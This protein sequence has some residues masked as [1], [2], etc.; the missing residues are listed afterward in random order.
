MNDFSSGIP[1]STADSGPT[2][3]TAQDEA[4]QGAQSRRVRP[5]QAP[6]V[7]LDPLQFDSSIA[8]VRSLALKVQQ[9]SRSV[10]RVV[11]QLSSATQVDSQG[12]LGSWLPPHPLLPAVDRQN[13]VDLAPL[14]SWLRTS[15][16]EHNV[17]TGQSESPSAQELAHLRKTTLA[18][19]QDLVRSIEPLFKEIEVFLCGLPAWTDIMVE[20][21]AIGIDVTAE[22]TAWLESCG[23]KVTDSRV[24]PTQWALLL[25]STAQRLEQRW[26]SA[27][28]M[29]QQAFI[30]HLRSEFIGSLSGALQQKLGQVRKVIEAD[31]D[32]TLPAELQWIDRARKDVLRAHWACA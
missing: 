13:L 29:Y 28:V 6:C 24:T 17:E 5:E 3:S 8:E 10:D 7:W 21:P 27:G 32:E 20:A 1:A 4:A 31:E 16:L 18:W 26:L 19:T 9:I 23:V 25:A 12:H 22:M 30:S 2:A 15:L 11:P 14:Q